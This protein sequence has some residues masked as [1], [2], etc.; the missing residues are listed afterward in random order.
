MKKSGCVWRYNDALYHH[1]VKGMRWGVRRYQNKD[2][3]LTE[4]GKNRYG[5]AL[6]LYQ[7]QAKTYNEKGIKAQKRANTV[8]KAV[9][10]GLGIRTVGAYVLYETGAEAVGTMLAGPVGGLALSALAYYYSYNRGKQFVNQWKSVDA[11]KKMRQELEKH[12]KE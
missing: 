6:D 2:G 12:K 4:E 3:T 1:G 8:A 11:E 5:T 7:E 10:A 9:W